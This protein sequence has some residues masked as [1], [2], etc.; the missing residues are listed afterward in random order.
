M[1]RGLFWAV[2][3]V[4]AISGGFGCGFFFFLRYFKHTM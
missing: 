1:G 3:V 2:V 4:V